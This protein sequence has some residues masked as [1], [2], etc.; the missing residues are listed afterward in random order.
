MKINARKKIIIT[1]LAL[2]GLI[3]ILFAGIFFINLKIKNTEQSINDFLAS[4]KNKSCRT[5]DLRSALTKIRDTQKKVEQYNEFLFQKGDE[6]KLITD[7]ETIAEKNNMTQNILN[8]TLDNNTGNI[9][10]MTVDIGGE[11]K[12]A[13]KYLLMLEQHPYF[14]NIENLEFY[15]TG[16]FAKDTGSLLVNLRLR[17]TLYAN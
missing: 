11:F 6:F 13:L 1:L 5:E 10:E 7:L 14:L 16:G 15:P 3:L 4:L 2:I 8:S 9:I 17:L 12:N